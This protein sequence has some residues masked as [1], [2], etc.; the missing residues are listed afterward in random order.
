MRGLPMT[1]PSGGRPRRLTSTGRRL[2]ATVSSTTKMDAG[3]W[4]TTW[5][6]RA[7]ILTTI[8]TWGCSPGPSPDRS[9]YASTSL[10]SR[11]TI[12]GRGPWSRTVT[13]TDVG[14]EGRTTISLESRL[15]ASRS[16]LTE[17]A[18]GF[19][20]VATYHIATAMATA[21]TK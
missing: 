2:L 15:R 14:G 12:W 16:T 20:A 17:R 5:T 6:S 11:R 8:G 7:G 13:L 4:S 19:S 10:G 18:T 9:T 1:T 3:L 21:S